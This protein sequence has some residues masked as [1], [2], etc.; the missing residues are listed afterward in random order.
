MFE[1]VCDGLTYRRASPLLRAWGS[2]A[3]LGSAMLVGGC[4]REPTECLI[5]LNEG[6]LVVT[7]IRGPQSSSDDS[8]GQWFELYNTTDHAL[9]LMGLRGALRPLRGSPVD[10][11]LELTFMV[12]EPLPLEAGAYVVLG[13]LALD[14]SRR[15]EVDYSINGDFRREPSRVEN[16]NGTVFEVPPSENADPLELFTNA[17]LELFACDRLLDDVIYGDLPEAG[18]LSYDGSLPPD[19]DDNDDLSHWCT[20]ATEPPSDGPQTAT[21][22]PGSG[23][24][25]NRPCP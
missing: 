17:R 9:D 1:L 5:D 3:L 11:E 25:A 23:G 2:I 19:A 13:T 20:D 8:R 24:E 14:P 18:T 15:P 4:L 6:D 16:A 7:E 12:R 21:G 10:G 22:L